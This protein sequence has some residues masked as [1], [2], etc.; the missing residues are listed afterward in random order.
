M[1]E[2]IDNLQYESKYRILGYNLIAGIDE[3]GRGPL[4]GPV[5]A[6]CCIMDMDNI[7]DR[8]TDSKKIS[9]KKRARLFNEI[10]ENAISYGI[11]IVDVETIE[12][13]NILNAAKLAMKNAYEEMDKDADIV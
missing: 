13:I 11:G 4:A 8:I 2:I 3:A 9:E 1:K 12:E 6:A 5:V 7:I 10:K